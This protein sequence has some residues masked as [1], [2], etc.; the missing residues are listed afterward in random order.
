MGLAPV[1]RRSPRAPRRLLRRLSYPAAL[2]IV[3]CL[4]A[5]FLIPPYWMVTG[6]L[7]AQLVTVA[8]PPELVPTSPTLANWQVVL[9]SNIPIWRW[10]GNSLL[11]AGATMLLSVSVSAFAGYSFGKKKFAGS[12]PLFLLL[13]ATMMLPAQVLLIPLY[14][15]VRQFH[16]YDTYMGMVLP[17]VMSPFGVF[18]IKQFMATI[19][20]EILAAARMDGVSEWG[21]FRW[22]ILPLSG[23]ALAALAIFTFTTAWNNFMWQ[24]LMA[25]D[26][27]M[28]T[29]PVGVAAMSRTP[30]GA[31]QTVLNVGVLMAGGTF[32]ALP[33][34]LIFLVFQRQFT[35]GIT[36]GAVKG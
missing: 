15:L 12:R 9:G 20:N 3:T 4:A 7:K 17:L 24:L 16:L 26:V 30:I 21:M 22:I 29:L 8:M 28:Y 2:A 32:A 34:I 6:S 35:Q 31:D 10:L 18:L 11:V 5:L 23:P 19:P 33:M 13:L 14:I 36:M 1:R 25:S 27:S